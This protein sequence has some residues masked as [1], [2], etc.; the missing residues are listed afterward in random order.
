M[1]HDWFAV[2][3]KTPD[4]A[5]CSLIRQHFFIKKNPLADTRGVNNEPSF[6][7]QLKRQRVT[8]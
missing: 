6:V 7:I 1:T 8:V 3:K 2:N 5:A 4:F